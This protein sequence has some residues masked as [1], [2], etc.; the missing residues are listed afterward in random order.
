MNVMLEEQFLQEL[1]ALR[2]RMK[3]A[4]RFVRGLGISD[5]LYFVN[6]TNSRASKIEINSKTPIVNALV[7]T[8]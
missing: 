3:P 7:E 2:R 5:E 4:V 1:V 8:P 6:C